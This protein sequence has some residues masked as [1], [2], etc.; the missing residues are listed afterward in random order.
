MR[1][2]RYKNIKKFFERLRSEIAT[3]NLI[4]WWGDDHYYV[5][6]LVK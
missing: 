1:I 5:M 6:K 4:S 3:N 2:V